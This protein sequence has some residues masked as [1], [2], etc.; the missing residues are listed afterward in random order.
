METSIMVPPTFLVP[1][2]KS[3]LAREMQDMISNC[4]HT[5]TQRTSNTHTHT[6]NRWCL[7][8]AADGL[9]LLGGV[10]AVLVL[11]LVDLGDILLLGLLGRQGV[12]D[13]LLPG[14]VLGLALFWGV[15]C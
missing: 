14:V 12:V 9:G 6:L 2:P 15:S 7:G 11:H 13:H 3:L 10:V 8:G 5:H 4:A 1:S